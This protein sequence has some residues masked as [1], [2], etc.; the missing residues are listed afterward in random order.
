MLGC[1][2][3]VVQLYAAR[4]VGR[5]TRVA[6]IPVA[7]CL[8]FSVVE[9]AGSTPPDWV[10]AHAPTMPVSIS[11]PNAD[12]RALANNSSL[13]IQVKVESIPTASV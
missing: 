3:L 2:A 5:F 1:I 6:A 10:R 13:D 7:V 12:P 4:F 11:I 8:I 9:G